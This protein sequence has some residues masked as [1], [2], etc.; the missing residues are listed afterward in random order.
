V[1]SKDRAKA[2]RIARRVM[3]GA[4]TINDHL[5][6]HGLA[7]TPWGG[8]KESG[9]GRTHGDIGFGEMTQPQVI[10]DDLL[11]F[12]RRNFWWQPFNKT[13]YNGVRGVLDF[14]HGRSLKE[15]AI[16]FVNMYV[17]WLTSFIKR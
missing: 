17:A 2:K 5:V 16:G 10:V 4:V 12:A 9:I 11:P 6:S 14:M 15:R 8:F 1:W 13:T 7:E 3:A